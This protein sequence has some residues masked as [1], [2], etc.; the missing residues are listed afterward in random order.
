LTKPA[1]LTSLAKT[2]I[3]FELVDAA[4]LSLAPATFFNL[5]L[6]I[7]SRNAAP[8]AWR[9]DSALNVSYRWLN[10]AG[11]PVGPE[12]QRTRLVSPLTSGQTVRVDLTGDSPVDVGAYRLIVS[13]VLEGAHWACDVG[14]SGWIGVEAQVTVPP[15]WPP[16]LLVSPG[17]KALR[18]ALAGRQLASL[19]AD[20][21]EGPKQVPEPA[22]IVEPSASAIEAAPIM[23][24]EPSP[25]AI[26]PAPTPAP[27]AIAR[28]RSS[29]WKKVRAWF[30]HF[31]GV[32]EMRQAVEELLRRSAEQEAELR[33]T[34]MELASLRDGSAQ[35]A[36]L[37]DEFHTFRSTQAAKQSVLSEQL[38]GRLAEQRSELRAML[39]RLDTL[40]GAVSSATSTFTSEFSSGDLVTEV[41]ST[42]RQISHWADMQN[43]QNL[44]EKMEAILR[45][46]AE[47]DAELS[48]GDMVTE[49]LSTL[50]QVALWA[51]MHGKQNL[52]E[53]MD[54]SVQQIRNELHAVRDAQ[55]ASMTNVGALAVSNSTKMDSLLRRESIALPAAKLVLSRSEFGLLA[56]Q[57][58]D[59]AAVAY[60]SSGELPESA[61]VSIVKQLL[62]PGDCFLDVG[63]NVGAYTLLGARLVG[64][65]G[66][67]V[68]VEPAPGTLH[69]L[70]TTIGINGIAHIVDLHECA[71]GAEDGRATLNFGSTSGHNSLLDLPEGTAQQVEIIVAT[72]A[73]ILGTKVPSLIKIDVEGWELE[74]LDGL[75]PLFELH[76]DIVVIVE[77]SPVH[78]QRSGLTVDQWVKRLR[79][80]GRQIWVIEDEGGRIS[81]LSDSKRLTDRGA[82]LLVCHKL[83][84]SLMPLQVKP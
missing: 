75:R 3:L 8:V 58:D 36:L 37:R 9:E 12:G 69:A 20:W 67:V 19:L 39:D 4:A 1:R 38:L 27:A 62:S 23:A 44:P 78:I 32:A 68:A 53:K 42:L 50:R 34:R 65:N 2:D 56:I 43:Q 55:I 81:P 66:K 57:Q 52:P 40:T 63:A 82:N 48:S 80:F 76:K 29:P 33:A 18:G 54:V 30:R 5:P 59:V 14:Q 28:R 31:L 16:H 6:L 35:I 25:A 10:E 73:A 77:C 22:Y 84:T 79:W 17:G 45:R 51:D 72:G 60:Y 64:P 71:L 61:T 7:T 26:E 15:A 21:K 47:F 41:L 70:R 46:S 49:V 83:P 24:V 74:V 11:I 13:L